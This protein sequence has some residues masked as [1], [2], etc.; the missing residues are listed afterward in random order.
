MR[1]NWRRA[2]GAL[3]A[4]A[5]P[6]ALPAG[7]LAVPS[8]YTVEAKVGPADAT[9]A[10]DPTGAN[11][12]ETQTR[13]VVSAD[14]FSF[15]YAETNGVTTDGVLDY[16][17]LPATYRASATAVQKLAFADAE[18]GVQAHATCD[19]AALRDQPTIA[20]WQPNA[21]SDPSYDYVPW[22]KTAAGLGDDPRS[23]LGVV[24]AATRVDL[25]ALST[26]AELRAACEGIGG[27]FV[28]AD[29]Q[30]GVATAL[31]ANAVA[32]LQS[33]ITRL[34]GDV[35]TL[36]RQVTTARD[37]QR[38]AETTYQSFFTR[39]I[40]LTLAAKRF[41]PRYGV[42]LVTGAPTDVVRITVE[43][44]RR[45]ARR[46][47]LSDTVLVE[48]VGE[49]DA[50]GAVLQSLKPDAE[51]AALLTRWLAPRARRAARRGRRARSARARTI[52]VKVL[53]VSGGNTDSA[54]ATLTR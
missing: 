7:A 20:Q 18:T 40:E 51:T 3:A 54:R 26:A 19:V 42:A 13:Y 46:I 49:I 11:L 17:A 14:G 41:P 48:T 15:G 36:R 8:V 25:S 22:Q 53:A 23:W 9:Y 6:A 32:P 10:R 50:E 27:R 34:Q 43:V 47:G 44:T 39:P 24:R 21:G 37:A 1:L 5:L 16:S 12:T 31:I 33:Q 35:S 38:L 4:L 52:P 2:L 28:P 30:S 29:I 45:L